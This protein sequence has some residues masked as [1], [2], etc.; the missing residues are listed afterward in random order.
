MKNSIPTYQGKPTAY[1]DHNILGLLVK[2]PS[3]SFK[4]ELRE[5]F[6]ILYSD[7]NLKEIK[8]TGENGSLYLDVLD[9]LKA[10]VFKISSDSSF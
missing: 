9:D 7:E 4:E 10:V 1:L 8:R 5:K 2:N 6:Q 3:L